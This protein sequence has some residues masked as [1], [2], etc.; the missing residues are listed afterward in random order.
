VVDWQWVQHGAT[1]NGQAWPDRRGMTTT[2][3]TRGSDDR[4]LVAVWRNKE[5]ANLPD[6]ARGT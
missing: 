2:V 1:M 5:L 6:A 3:W 4:W